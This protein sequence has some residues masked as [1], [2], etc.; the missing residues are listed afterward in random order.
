M[1]CKIYTGEGRIKTG[2]NCGEIN[3]W[4][5]LGSNFLFAFEIPAN[6]QLAGNL[7]PLGSKFY[8]K[9]NNMLIIY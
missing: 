7:W 6:I 8:S 1:G 4:A 3:V 2:I 5:L 9:T